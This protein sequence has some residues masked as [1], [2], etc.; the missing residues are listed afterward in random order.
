M[1]GRAVKST[2]LP[3]PPESFPPL[4]G[5]GS[6]FRGG[7]PSGRPRDVRGTLRRL[8]G[9]AEPH[10]RKVLVAS[11]FAAGATGLA[12]AGPY[13]LGRA[14][15]ALLALHRP[16]L[17][18]FALLMLG[19]YLFS[20]L[21]QGAQGVIV[22]RLAQEMTADLR[23]RLF[24][25]L[26]ALPVRFFDTQPQGDV[27][28]RLTNDLDALNRVLSA[29]ASQLVTGVLSLGGILVVLFTLDLRLALASMVFLPLMVVLATAVG[30]RTRGAFRQYQASLGS[31]NAFLEDAYAG[32]SALVALGRE[33]ATLDRFRAANAGVRS[34]GERAMA[35]AFLAMPLMGILANA[36][37]AVVGGVGGWLALHG[38]VS[39]GTLAA[40]ITYSRRFA[41]P[42]RQLGDLYNQ[43]QG[44]L[45][46]AERVF[47]ILDTP[48]DEERAGAHP[49]SPPSVARAPLTSR[50]RGEV[51][52]EN[53]TFSYLPGVPVLKEVSFRASPGERIALVGPTG[54]GKT[55][56]VN[57]LARFYEPDGGRILVDGQDIR[58][59]PL[60]HLRRQVG[61][62]LQ[63]TFL[64]GGTVRENLLF[65]R[66][67]A[68][69]EEMVAAA[70]LARADGFIRRLPQGYDTLLPPDGGGLS[71][72]QR[73]LLAIA[74]ALL[75]DP[76]ILVLDE[77]TSS[78]DTRTEALLQEGLR[79]LMQGRTS[80]VIA[81][82]ISTV[83]GADRIVVLER[84]RVVETGTH[85]ELMASGGPYSRL[86]L[87]Q[88]RGPRS[89][90][91]A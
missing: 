22:A 65:G 44:A 52:F 82:R 2:A 70:R 91:L 18:R 67:E 48:V 80:L 9:L 46:G 61:L 49:T 89:R 10:K 26:H 38:L 36:N 1:W 20:S 30:R 59:I 41:E 77:A 32:H 81:H 29:Q 64:F 78:V 16:D 5:P 17:A 60:P 57:L 50:F 12:L 87:G 23:S 83:V 40:F 86:F 76:A 43:V 21:A 24:G 27:M 88:S 51:R 53:V 71:Q 37:V 84:G 14:V 79:A 34:T 28:S 39:V 62:V 45:A 35:R 75:A 56:V 63:Q 66:P 54:A 31:L 58:E 55:T 6:R 42:L 85:E 8:A 13:F 68:T 33:S 72:G 25:H 15:D 3:T 74:R 73:Q 19:S 47:Q 4:S 7:G 11:L 69:D 90:S